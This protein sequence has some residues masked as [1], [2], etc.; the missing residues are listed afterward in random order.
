M[1]EALAI[2]QSQRLDHEVLFPPSEPHTISFSPNPSYQHYLLMHKVLVGRRGGMQ[3]EAIHQNL[4]DESMPRYLTAAGWAAAEAAVVRSDMSVEDRIALLHGGVDC[5]RRALKNQN[6]LNRVGPDI[7]VEHSAPHRLALDIAVAPLLEGMIRGGIPIG[8]RRQVFEDCLAVA[9]GNA[10]RMRLMKEAGDKAALLDHIG[11]GH[12]C[13]ALLAFN[14]VLSTDWFAIPSTIRSDSGHYYPEQTHDLSIVHQVE[15]SLRCIIPIEVKDGIR[16]RHYRRYKALL[17]GGRE[18]L[19][20]PE[21]YLPERTLAAIVA[22]HQGH[23]TEEQERL[24]ESISEGLITMVKDYYARGL[25]QLAAGRTPTIFSG[26]VE[27]AS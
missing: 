11:F 2:D 8:V 21:K 4:R 13:N 25:G 10:T 22:T 23:A 27:I 24:V 19:A 14:G 12:E 5:W 16:L 15:G 7:L 20:A 17:I 3:L 18:H 26:N 1:S 6:W 9:Q